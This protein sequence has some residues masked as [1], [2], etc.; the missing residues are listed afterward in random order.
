MRRKKQGR[1]AL[2]QTRAVYPKGARRVWWQIVSQVC[3]DLPEIR[4]LREAI[5]AVQ[6]GGLENECEQE[7]RAKDALLE[8]NGQKL[9]GKRKLGGEVA[10]AQRQVVGHL[11]S[12]TFV[13]GI[14][15]D[16]PILPLRCDGLTF[17][18]FL[19]PRSFAS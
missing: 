7:V 3:F 18:R 16:L 5:M 17:S 14:P 10:R 2:H 11:C 1:R 12:P 15:L 13:K 8:G 9:A 4:L 6:K 19:V